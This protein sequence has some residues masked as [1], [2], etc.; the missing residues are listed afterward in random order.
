M[1]IH[2]YT[3]LYVYTKTT[4]HP[5][6]PTGE[7]TQP[8]GQ[9]YCPTIVSRYHCRPSRRVCTT[10]EGQRGWRVIHF[11]GKYQFLCNA[12]FQASFVSPPLCAGGPAVFPLLLPASPAMEALT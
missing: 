3:H 8:Q 7:P 1:N 6:G 12:K 10:A 9:F 2:V 5:A 11:P 4:Q